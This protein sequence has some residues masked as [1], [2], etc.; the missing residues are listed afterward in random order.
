MRALL[1][2]LTHRS[3][4][5]YK[6]SVAGAGVGL[7]VVCVVFF[8]GLFSVNQ[9]TV[10][11]VSESN[12]QIVQG[13][14]DS[15]NKN[16]KLSQ[17]TLFFS[18]DNIK[19]NAL[20]Q[21]PTIANIQVAKSLPN[22]IK[23]NITDRT[24]AGIW[25]ADTTPEPTF[26]PATTTEQST[27]T[28]EAEQDPETQADAESADQEQASES[29]PPLASIVEPEP[30]PLEC[31]YYGN[32]GVIFQESP[33][34]S[35]GFLIREVRDKRYKSVHSGVQPTTQ[36][37]EQNKNKQTA[38][39]GNQVLTEQDIAQLDLLYAALTMGVE[40]PT[41]ITFVDEY[42]M[43]VGFQQGWEVYFSRQDPL[44]KQVENLAAVLNQH[45]KN[46]KRFLDYVDVRYGNKIF[47]KYIAL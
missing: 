19:R 42:E 10:V 17:N 33:N 13:Y 45:I 7:V 22:S 26:M 12:K 47:Y 6:I 44:V 11:G 28:E 27:E 4:R 40:F 1:S 15:A 3:P 37:I 25:C 41:Y 31:F 29:T 32:D 16:K 18:L 43:R 20:Q 2:M 34:T 8:S 9:I 14:I 21:H 5:F 39:L 36:E 24:R 46:N 38:Y 30:E 35:Q 23:V